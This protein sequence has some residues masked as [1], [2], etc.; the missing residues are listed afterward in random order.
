[1]LNH[2]VFRR[3]DLPAAYLPDGGV[4]A[5]TRRSLMLEVEAQDGPHRFFGVDR[6]GIVSEPGV[7]L[8]SMK[9]RT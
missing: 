8:I 2:N 9:R 5:L 4:I 6:R 7:W 3:Q 1:M